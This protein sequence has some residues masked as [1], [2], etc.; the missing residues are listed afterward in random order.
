MNIIKNVTT[1]KV[2]KKIGKK[3]KKRNICAR[4][5]CFPRILKDMNHQLSE[6]AN[7]AKYYTQEHIIIR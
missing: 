1:K 4:K 2:Y 3:E 7:C 5:R 6:L